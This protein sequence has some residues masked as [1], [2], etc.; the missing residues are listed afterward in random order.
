MTLVKKKKSVCFFSMQLVI[1]S[2]L[3]GRIIITHYYYYCPT[4]VDVCVTEIQFK[5]KHLNRTNSSAGF[6]ASQCG[7]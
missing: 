2:Y 6:L 7:S 4:T 5:S 3:T 1:Q